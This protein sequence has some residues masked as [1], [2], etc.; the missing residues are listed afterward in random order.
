M[1]TRLVYKTRGCIVVPLYVRRDNMAIQWHEEECD[2]NHINCTVCVSMCLCAHFRAVRVRSGPVA[3]G[4][5]VMLHM[6]TLNF[7]WWRFPVRTLAVRGMKCLSTMKAHLVRGMKC[8]STMKAHLQHCRD[9][10]KHG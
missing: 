1:G 7:S 4:K 6:W 10:Q 8:L 2:A 3:E 9:Q 5:A